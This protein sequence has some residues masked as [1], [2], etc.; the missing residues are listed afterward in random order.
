MS[1]MNLKYF[2]YLIYRM[3]FT[4]L[5]QF[6]K[7]FRTKVIPSNG[8]NPVYNEEPFVF[9]KVVLPELAVLRLVLPELAVLRLVL[10]ELAILR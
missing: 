10:S 1:S 9:R 4:N 5:L 6:R 7:E 8:L 3:Y 2:I